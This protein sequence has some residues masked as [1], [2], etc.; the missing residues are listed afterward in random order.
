MATRVQ[1]IRVVDAEFQCYFYGDTA[2]RRFE[3]WTRGFSAI[4]MATPRPKLSVV[5]LGV[6]LAVLHRK[7]TQ[8]KHHSHIVSRHYLIYYKC[9]RFLDKISVG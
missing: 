1:K 6:S 3:L 7:M 4:P 2:S 8:L 9:I 5:L